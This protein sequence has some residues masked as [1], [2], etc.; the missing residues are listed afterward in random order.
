[1]LLVPSVGAP[2]FMP[3]LDV[4]RAR[5]LMAAAVRWGDLSGRVCS[6]T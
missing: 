4:I 6:P 3:D 5:F 1:M 2:L